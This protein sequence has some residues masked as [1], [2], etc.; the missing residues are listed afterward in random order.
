MKSWNT[1]VR[2][3]AFDLMN[4]FLSFRCSYLPTY[5]ISVTH[6]GDPNQHH[7]L[8]PAQPNLRWVLEERKIHTSMAH[9]HLDIFAVEHVGTMPLDYVP[10][11]C[12]QDSQVQQ[13]KRA[14]RDQRKILGCPGAWAVL[15]IICTNVT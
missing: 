8:A 5:V 13:L 6:Y 1:P 9:I 14:S 2:M 10:N 7:P 12:K 11:S 3:L 15:H 4:S